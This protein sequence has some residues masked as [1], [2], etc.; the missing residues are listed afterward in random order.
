MTESCGWP[1]PDLLSVSPALGSLKPSSH[2]TMLPGMV[3]LTLFFTGVSLTADLLVTEKEAGTLARDWSL[4]VETVV[5]LV[6]QVSVQM[7]VVMSQV[8]TSLLL[9]A[10]LY[11]LSAPVLAG[12]GLLVVLQSVCGM[13]WGILISL[14]TKSREQAVQVSLALI[15]PLFLLS[16]ILWPVISMPVWLQ[17]VSSV[18]PL[19]DVTTAITSIILRGT[20]SPMLLLR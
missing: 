18:L 13:V 9:L 8:L 3:S 11:P 20:V 17:Y 15:F 14:V 2:L 19:T 12:V 4:G 6:C 5:C 10:L 7:I 1:A 16:G